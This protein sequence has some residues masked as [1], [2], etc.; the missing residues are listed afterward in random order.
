MIGHEWQRLECDA[1]S[2]TCPIVRWWTGATTSRWPSSTGW[3]TCCSARTSSAR[4][5]NSTAA[6][7]AT[8]RWPATLT[9]CVR[10]FSTPSSATFPNTW[11]NRAST[12]RIWSPSTKLDVET[13]FGAGLGEGGSSLTSP[14]APGQVRGWLGSALFHLDWGSVDVQSGVRR[15]AFRTAVRVEKECYLLIGCCRWPMGGPYSFSTTRSPF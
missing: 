13:R 10:A 5:T 15:I 14:P 3:R 6:I 2:A 11:L 12:W 8:N 7:W 1:I 9:G 4:R